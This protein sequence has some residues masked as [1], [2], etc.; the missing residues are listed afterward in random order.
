VVYRPSTA[1][2][3]VRFSSTNFSYWNYGMYQWGGVGDIPLATDFDGDGRT[4][5]VVY[6]PSNA[7]WYV[8][9]SSSSYSYTNW[10]AH[11]WGGQGDVPIVSR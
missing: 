10:V 4:D 7:S 3:F 1:E 8:R 11:Q 2:W 9:Y 6:R 5:L